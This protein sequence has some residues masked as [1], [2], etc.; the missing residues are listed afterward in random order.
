MHT[1]IKKIF[2][3]LAALCAAV[4]LAACGGSESESEAETVSGS[5]KPL[6]AAPPAYNGV[7]GN[8]RLT[9]S[10]DG[11]VA[12]ISLRGLVP[13]DRYVAHLHTG[14][15]ERPDAGGPHFQFNK[16]GADEPPNEIHFSLRANEAGEAS[17]RAANKRQVPAGEAGSVVVHVAGAH[18]HMAAVFVH[19]GEHHDKDRKPTVD[20]IA[21]A[22]LETPRGEAGGGSAEVPTIVV[23][24]GEPVGGVQKLEYSAGDEIRFRVESDIAE[25]VHVHGYDL[26]KEVQPGGSVEFSFPADIEGIFEVELEQSAVQLIELQVNP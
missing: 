10:E 26:L 2:A 11:T 23:R 21:C 20:K 24:D 4:A 5:F 12:A 16:G 25:E 6:P 8:A 3:L 9:R 14:T 18:T 22:N 19:E 13:G 7:A 17:A 15:C 1:D